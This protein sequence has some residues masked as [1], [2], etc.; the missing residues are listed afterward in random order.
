V[1]NQVDRNPTTAN[2]IG[3]DPTDRNPV[4][5]R[6]TSANLVG[7]DRLRVTRASVAHA[8]CLGYPRVTVR[9]SSAMATSTTTSS[10]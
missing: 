1:P 7:Y 5:P 4:E 9:P 2:R 3:H 10:R 6:P 8:A